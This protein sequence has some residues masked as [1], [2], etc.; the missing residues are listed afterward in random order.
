[1]VLHITQQI[2]CFFNYSTGIWTDVDHLVIKKQ[3]REDAFINS[4]LED[5]D[6]MYRAIVRKVGINY[7]K[8]MEEVPYRTN[9]WY[10]RPVVITR[11]TP[12]SDEME[13]GYI[14]V[15]ELFA[16]HQHNW[17][18]EEEEVILREMTEAEMAATDASELDSDEEI[19]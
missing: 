16:K 1:L 4:T 11:K 6:I 13:L 7:D 18:E 3:D 2:L 19:F 10:S 15:V 17:N 12:V 8:L 5:A 9:T 14:K